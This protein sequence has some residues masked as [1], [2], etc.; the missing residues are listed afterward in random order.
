MNVSKG[1]LLFSNPI[2]ASDKTLTNVVLK[3]LCKNKL[4]KTLQKT[5]QPT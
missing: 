3:F 5:V 4:V 1:V 2:D